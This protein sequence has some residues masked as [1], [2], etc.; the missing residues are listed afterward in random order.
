MREGISQNSSVCS[1]SS[2]RR[3]RDHREEHWSFY[4]QD[5]NA[6]PFRTHVAQRRGP[7]KGLSP[8]GACTT[9][10]GLPFPWTLNVLGPCRPPPSLT[11]GT[12]TE[13]A[14]LKNTIT[15]EPILN[16]SCRPLSH[17]VGGHKGIPGIYT[18]ME[19]Q[20]GRALVPLMFH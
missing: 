14:L 1:N 10:P 4:V 12:A 11:L 9:L 20:K 3:L 15:I 8:L 16:T 7:V 18:R 2:S 19:Q 17:S 13:T 5:C 6:K